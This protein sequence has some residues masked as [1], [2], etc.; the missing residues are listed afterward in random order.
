MMDG[1]NYQAFWKFIKL[2]SDYVLLPFWS[3]TLQSTDT[4]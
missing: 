1:M 4:L 3:S 2:L